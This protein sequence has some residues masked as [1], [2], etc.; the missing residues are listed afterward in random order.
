MVRVAHL[1]PDA[2]RV[3]VYINGEPDNAL[4]NLSYKTIS[5]YQPVPAATQNIKIYATG[6]TS[7]PLIEADVDLQGGESYTVGVVGL[8]EN[9]SFAAQLYEDDSSVPAAGNAKLRVIHAA[10]DVEIVDIAPTPQGSDPLFAQLGFPNATSYAEVP[11]Q[12]Y[13]LEAN[14]T[15]TST[16]AFAIPGATLSPGVVYSAFV[17]GQAQSDT[18]E[19]VV[20]TDAGASGASKATGSLDVVPGTLPTASMPETGGASLAV[21]FYGAVLI[22]AGLFVAYLRRRLEKSASR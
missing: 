4:T 16:S 14:A 10:P 11:A 9:E 22:C 5:P 20:A 13:T 8:V 15:G 21:L 18:L 6:D 12:S 3:D 2:P 7:Q 17:V 19:V 1:S